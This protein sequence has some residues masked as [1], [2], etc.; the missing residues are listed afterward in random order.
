MKTKKR[1]RKLL[2]AKQRAKYLKTVIE[3]MR[4]LAELLAEAKAFSGG[5]ETRG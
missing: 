2:R 1:A 4:R 5:K 3:P